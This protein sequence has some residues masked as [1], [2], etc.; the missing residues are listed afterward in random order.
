MSLLYSNTL[1]FFIWLFN[2]ISITNLLIYRSVHQCNN[3]SFAEVD[4]PARSSRYATETH[5]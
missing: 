1:N 3:K 2:H 4:I 5:V